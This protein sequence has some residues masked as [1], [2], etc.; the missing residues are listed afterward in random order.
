MNR[1]EIK[2]LYTRV[3]DYKIANG[4]INAPSNSFIKDM[5]LELVAVCKDDGEYKENNIITNKDFF[6][7]AKIFI[8]KEVFL[9]NL[10]NYFSSEDFNHSPKNGQS[11]FGL[12]QKIFNLSSELL[13]F[14]HS[15]DTFLPYPDFKV[16][17]IYAYQ[18]STHFNIA[19]EAN[20]P[21]IRGIF[22]KDIFTKKYSKEDINSSMTN[23]GKRAIHNE[24]MFTYKPMETE[25]PSSGCTIS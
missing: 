7:L 22:G 4:M 13:G 24:S 12:T 1:E 15:F 23:E 25:K 21:D 11:T 3:L 17:T 18:Q 14:S 5:A 10:T 16:E 19:K 9:N 20:D 2:E 8:G 6:L